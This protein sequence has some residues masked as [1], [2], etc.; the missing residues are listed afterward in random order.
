MDE[1]LSKHSR[2]VRYITPERGGQLSYDGNIE[3]NRSNNPQWLRDVRRS[4]QYSNFRQ[5]SI[6]E[7]RNLEILVLR[8]IEADTKIRASSFTFK[9]EIER[10]NQLMDRIQIHRS[11]SAGLDLLKIADQQPANPSELSSG[12]SELVSLAIEILYFSY[13]CQQD[14]YK[15]EQNWLLLDEPDV[16]LHPDLQFRLMRLLVSAMENV[17]GKVAIATHSTT[18]LS[19]LCYLNA[20]TRIALKQF[21]MNQLK[22]QRPTNALRD[23]LPM[24]GAHPLSNIFNER[25]PLIVEGEDDERIWQAAVRHSNGRLSVYP[26]VAGNVQSMNQYENAAASLMNSVYDNATA[27]SLRDRDNDQYEID[28]LP[29]VRR[30]RLK[31]RNA[32]NLILT[33]DV[34]HEL[35]TKWQDLKPN[36]EKWIMDNPTHVQYENALGF[37]DSNWDRRKFQLK[38]LR[39]VLVGITGSTMPWEVAVG[40]AIA[41]LP[42]KRFDSEH[43]LVTYLGPM[44][45]DAL[46]LDRA[47]S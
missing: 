8:S 36:L 15:N 10:I 2:C 40:R 13:L 37:Q 7:F 19:S 12:E 29:P 20:D 21:E 26:C 27:Y 9:S 25:P 35:G 47:A 24:F 22:F 33:D 30:F 34:L 3:T 23:V 45:V 18:I 6:V 39:N 42:E 16:H 11:D 43:S 41:R 14:A 1:T 5:S 38:D 32:E 17:N 28:D 4:N 44:L 46:G 31:C